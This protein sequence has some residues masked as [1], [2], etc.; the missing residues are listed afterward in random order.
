MPREDES[1]GSPSCGFPRADGQSGS[2]DG[3]ASARMRGMTQP[4]TVV[5]TVSPD[6]PDPAALR[7]AAAAIQ[8][9][10]LV[11]L[12]TET[13]YGLGANALDPEAVARIFAAKDRPADNPLIVHVD[14]LEMA[15]SLTA[16]WPEV[17]DRL[18]A[19][20]WPGPL[21]L[22]L[23]KMPHVP[24]I[25]TAGQPGVGLRMPAHPVALAL[26][27]AAGTP[28]AAPSANRSTRPS[29]TDAS[30]VLA[31]LEGRIDMSLDGGPATV[32]IESTVLSLL[33]DPPLV[34]R[35]G[36]ISL[37]QLHAI[38]PRIAYGA[39]HGKV[40]PGTRYRHY[41]PRSPVVRLSGAEALEA[42]AARL[43][44]E[45]KKAGV[46]SFQ[47]LDLPAGMPVLIVPGDPDGYAAEFYRAL[48]LLDGQ[49]VDCILLLDP[50]SGGRWDAVRDRVVRASG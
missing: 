45:G 33:T 31:D 44:A 28:I 34:L 42:E 21:T 8:Q 29:P 17:A 30:H 41:A 23:P 15:R 4:R 25:V 1:S 47:A 35:P 11:A 46:L 16:T 10:K 5:L 24:D 49:D 43:A 6:H 9:G 22:I 26:I 14:G 38:D 36:G 12:P 39:D 27:R 7:E 50:P 18:A 48:R 32:G 19:E 40:S 20:F 3:S 37:A 2:P 13:V